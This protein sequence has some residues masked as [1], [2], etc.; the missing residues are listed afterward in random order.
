ME[1]AKILKDKQIIVFEENMLRWRA[2]V[3]I[4]QEVILNR[5]SGEGVRVFGLRVE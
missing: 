1:N 4:A 3:N 5:L 2:T